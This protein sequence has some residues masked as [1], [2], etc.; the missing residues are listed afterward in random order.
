MSSVG[1]APAQDRCG[2]TRDRWLPVLRSDCCGLCI[3]GWPPGD[4]PGRAGDGRGILGDPGQLDAPGEERLDGGNGLPS[5]CPGI[6]N[7]I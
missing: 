2:S 6:F 4:C 3:I 7:K 5:V 1:T